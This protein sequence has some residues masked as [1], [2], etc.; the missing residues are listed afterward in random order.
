MTIKQLKSLID[1][2]PEISWRH[3]FNDFST[4]GLRIMSCMQTRFD[5]ERVMKGGS[6]TFKSKAEAMFWF[7]HVAVL[8]LNER[9]AVVTGAKVLFVEKIVEGGEFKRY[10]YRDSKNLLEAFPHQFSL[11]WK[12][13]KGKVVQRE[14]RVMR[15][16]LDAPTRL[17]FKSC[18]FD[19]KVERV[20]LYN[21]NMFTRFAITADMAA[22]AF[23]KSGCDDVEALI[24]PF[25]DHI[26]NIWCKRDRV[27][28]QFVVNW[29]AH[30][31]QKPWVKMG[32]VLSLGGEKGS[33]KGIIVEK[34]MDIMGDATKGGHGYHA[35]TTDEVLGKF[36]GHL[37]T[38]C[39]LF[40]DECKWAGV[41]K[42]KRASSEP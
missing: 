42:S 17:T 36:C 33:G 15:K 2:D 24:R 3:C 31:L 28:Y 23:E 11:K 38:T 1:I 13:D 34:L 39:L 5:A 18:V 19:P 9:F 32:S 29:M 6:K 22:E 12:E 4:D 27:T 26:Y 41:Q 7:N 35:T 16:W 20:N 30:L 25:L 37:A 14:F 10:V 8:R 21:L 40:M